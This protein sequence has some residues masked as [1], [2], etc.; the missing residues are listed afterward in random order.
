MTDAGRW[1]LRDS[2]C[3]RVP[4]LA[5]PRRKRES[6]GMRGVTGE[7]ADKVVEV[8]RADLGRIRATAFQHGQ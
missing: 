7:A 1:A 4:E 6:G 2:S 8:L 5:P 3:N